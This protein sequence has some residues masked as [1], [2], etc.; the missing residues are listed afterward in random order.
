MECNR[1]NERMNNFYNNVNDYFPS[2]IMYGHAYTPNQRLNKVFSPEEALRYGTIFPELVNV[3]EP[4]DSMETI[5]F[6]R[7]GNC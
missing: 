5:R 6:L 3:Y 2:K 4:C 1:V 7:G